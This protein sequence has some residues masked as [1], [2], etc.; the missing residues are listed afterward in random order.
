[1]ETFLKNFAVGFTGFII[2]SFS[3][4]LGDNK[5]RIKN[6]RRIQNEEFSFR[7]VV[8]IIKL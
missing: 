2:L 4:I 7:Y 8:G 6:G 5:K 3:H 1:M